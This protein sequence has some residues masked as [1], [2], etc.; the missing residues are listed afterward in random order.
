MDVPP[1][2]SSGSPGWNYKIL[3][4]HF[5]SPHLRIPLAYKIYANDVLSGVCLI[6]SAGKT[7]TCGSAS[8]VTKKSPDANQPWVE[9]ALG[10]ATEIQQ[11]MSW[12]YLFFATFILF[13]V[14]ISVAVA[15]NYVKLPR[16]WISGIAFLVP[17]MLAFT[18]AISTLELQDTLIALN[19]PRAAVTQAWVGR[20]VSMLAIQWLF[21]FCH[22]YFALVDLYLSSRPDGE[23]VEDPEPETVER[24]SARGSSVSGQSGRPGRPGR[25]GS[26]VRSNH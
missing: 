7:M 25:P 21:V 23:G 22:I 17:G 19:I 2:N 12:R 20:G 15:S 10:W 24:L 1:T 4:A 11:Q 13:I 26:T 3:I 9:A 18:S 14:A 8:H 6:S 5:G 16:W